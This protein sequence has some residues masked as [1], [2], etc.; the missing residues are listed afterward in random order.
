MAEQEKP[1]EEHAP[2]NFDENHE[3]K[4]DFVISEGLTTAGTPR[5][6]ARNGVAIR[7]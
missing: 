1:K 6:S 3:E 4:R 7:V 2:I 5:E